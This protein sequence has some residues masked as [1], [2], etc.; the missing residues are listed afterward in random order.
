MASS[1][2]RDGK[3][4]LKDPKLLL[5]L[6]YGLPHVGVLVDSTRALISMQQR[7]EA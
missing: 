2:F 3:V 7:T 5:Y 1:V 4:E 6:G